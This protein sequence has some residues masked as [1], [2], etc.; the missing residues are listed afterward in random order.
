MPG[1]VLAPT[2]VCFLL[3]KE[4]MKVVVWLLIKVG[5]GGER[6]SVCVCVC[7]KVH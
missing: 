3:S 7:F 5:N 1:V 6:E 2:V 4:S